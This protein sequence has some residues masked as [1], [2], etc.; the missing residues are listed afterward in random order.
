MENYE[1]FFKISNIYTNIHAKPTK[2]CSETLDEPVDS[3]IPL[4]NNFVLLR[5]K[6]RPNANSNLNSNLNPDNF[7]NSNSNSKINIRKDR[8]HENNSDSSHI[9][10]T[11]SNIPANQKPNLNNLPF[12]NGSRN[13]SS[14][15]VT[16]FLNTNNNIQNLINKD[17]CQNNFMN[18]C[19]ANLADNSHLFQSNNF[20]NYNYFGVSHTPL[21]S[22][23]DEIKKWMSRI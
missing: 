18:S 16:N 12:L 3:E 11:N 10:N 6:S 4:E 14:N 2:I 8:D 21:K 7:S 9:L 5:H 19:N 1:E 17:S 23:K 15:T 13:N 20:N 22:K